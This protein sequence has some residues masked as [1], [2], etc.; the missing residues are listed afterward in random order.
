MKKFYFVLLLLLSF[1]PGHLL[2]ACVITPIALN[3]SESGS[4]DS[5]CTSTNNPG[6]YA[7]YYTFTLA[8]N[9]EVTI[10]LSSSVDTFLF[11]LSGSG[12]NGS[13]LEFNDDIGSGDRNSSIV[14]AL[15]AGTY[16]IEATTYAQSRTGNF[17][18]SLGVSVPTAG[19]CDNYLPLNLEVSGSWQAGCTSTHR[20]SR[21]AKYF[22][23]TLSTEQEVIINL[24]SS[25][26][27]YMFLLQ[28]SG[29]NGAVIEEDDNDGVGSNSLI[30]R[31][32]TA[33]AYTIE[34]TTSA[35]TE[36]GDF[37]ISVTADETP[38][39]DCEYLINTGINVVGSWDPACPSTNREGRYASYYT[40]NLAS[41]QEVTIDLTSSKDT[42]LLLLQGCR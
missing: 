2:A 10:N 30:T 25:R 16:T 9:Q 14:K 26:D 37:T 23:F 31:T 15:P 24:Q 7:Q 8:N 33:G 29:R 13:V 5:D 19:D 34:A 32:L 42:Y 21:Y 4:W 22:T 18:V 6:A 27:T 12:Q 35:G 38:P 40:F 28:G 39:S 1:L 41:T 20:A 17:T 36:T 11:L 3:D